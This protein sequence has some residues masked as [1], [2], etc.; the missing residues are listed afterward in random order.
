MATM[1]YTLKEIENISWNLQDKSITDE[2]TA[3]INS[4]AD[5]V[6]SPTYDKTP[7]F[8]NNSSTTKPFNRK[9]KKTSEVIND[10]DWEAI[11]NFQKTELIKSEGIQ[12]D[13]DSI[14]SLI[15]RITEK[16][17]DLI[18]EKLTEKLDSFE[19]AITKSEDIN[20][21]GKTI[22]DM[23]TSNNFN[24]KTYAKLCSYLNGKY[25][26][27][28][29]IIDNNLKDYMN[30][31]E[32]IEVADPNENYDK[33]CDLNIVNDKRRA[34][35]L[36]LCNLY[37]NNI[38]EFEMIENIVFSL[39]QRIRTNMNDE[40][41]K[42]EHD[43]I[44]ENLLIIVSNIPIVKIKSD[45]KWKNFVDYIVKICAINVKDVKGISSKCKFK[46]MDIKALIEK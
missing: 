2:T 45:D 9:K 26:Y 25:D 22:L 6:A 27:I 33:F 46:H 24:S 38:V 13:I 7:V 44:S 32:N 37:E 16:T 35:S 15:N 8:N 40:T 29:T 3:L 19:E 39:Y 14:R 18:I 11:R 31:F 43:E 17:Y 5:Q 21:I 20:K 42:M 1:Y 36:F 4:L 23:A 34:M 41:K 10:E 28:K 30:L 12:K